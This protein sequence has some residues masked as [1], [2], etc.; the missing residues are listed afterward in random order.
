[1]SENGKLDKCYTA[2]EEKSKL[3]DK[4][5]KYRKLYLNGNIDE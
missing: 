3:Y 5:S 2:L 1:M 4:L